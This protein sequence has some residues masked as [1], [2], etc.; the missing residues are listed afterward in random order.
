MLILSI[1]LTANSN[2]AWTHIELGAAN[3]GPDGHTQDSQKKTVLAQLTVTG[4]R[5]HVDDLEQSGTGDYDPEYQFRVLFNTL[6]QLVENYGTDEGVFHI[7]DLFK[8]Y[9]DFAVEALEKYAKQKNYNNL[10]IEGVTGDYTSIDPTITLAKYDTELYNS[11]HLKNPEISFY[12]DHLDGYTLTSTTKSRAAARD[13]LQKLANLSH[14]GLY[15]F[16]I[17]YADFVPDIEVQEYIGK[18]KFYDRSNVWPV[19]PYVFPE[20]DGSLWNWPIRKTYEL[21]ARVYH[22]KPSTQHFDLGNFE[23]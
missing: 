1:N 10:T 9:V 17:A 18:N 13:R 23:L 15:F 22:I 4:E 20:D 19:M 11:A 2:V 21:L 6:D 8:N 5:N 16:P 3:Y 12:H 14:S 7:N